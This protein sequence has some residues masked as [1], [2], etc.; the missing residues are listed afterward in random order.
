MDDK[1]MVLMNWEVWNQLCPERLF[2]RIYM[3]GK[4]VSNKKFW[5]ELFAYFP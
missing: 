3:G 2:F 5:E 1:L 4:N